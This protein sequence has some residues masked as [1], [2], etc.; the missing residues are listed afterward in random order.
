M[1]FIKD[2]L[3]IKILLIIAV[4][5]LALIIGNPFGWAKTQTTVS[6]KLYYEAD[7]DFTN[8]NVDTISNNIQIEI[9][10]SQNRI[11]AELVGDKGVSSDYIEVKESENTLDIK[12]EGKKNIFININ[13]F[14]RTRRLLVTIPANIIEDINVSSV[15]GE[16]DIRDMEANNISFATTSGDIEFT[17]LT[18]KNEL[19]IKSI[20]G[21]VEGSKI[22]SNYVDIKTTSG[23]INVSNLV[24]SIISLHSVSGDIEIDSCSDVNRATIKTTSGD[25]TLFFDS[26]DGLSLTT[27]SVSGDFYVNGDK[28]S[29]GTTLIGS[30]EIGVSITTV[31]GNFNIK[32]GK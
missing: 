31:S 12:V 30:G 15:S 9:S 10:N 17:T 5:I 21:E 23:D 3:W 32:Q 13:P 20:S 1:A 28:I 22:N 18:A 16:L 8:L 19:K 14:E 25:G 2:S 6:N 7:R 26:G 4:I 11:T 27:K 24:G 29:S